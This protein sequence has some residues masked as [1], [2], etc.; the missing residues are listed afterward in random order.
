MYPLD[1]IPKWNKIC[2]QELSL[3][4]LFLIVSLFADDWFSKSFC[5]EDSCQTP[6]FSLPF[7]G[8]VALN[9][10]INAGDKYLLLRNVVI[11]Q[12]RINNDVG[13][14]FEKTEN[15]EASIAHLFAVIHFS[16]GLKFLKVTSTGN[17]L[18]WIL[19]FDKYSRVANILFCLGLLL[20][21]LKFPDVKLDEQSLKF[22]FFVSNVCARVQFLLSPLMW[23]VEYKEVI[24]FWF[25]FFRYLR[26]LLNPPPLHQ[27]QGEIELVIQM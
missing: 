9:Y 15:V 20:I 19:L 10:L 1:W 6:S 24:T 16:W 7:M 23:I 2:W 8:S 13:L 11:L 14:L 12:T 22:S 27:Q 26:T 4:S 17:V 21:I 3:L 25:E 18:D 5:E